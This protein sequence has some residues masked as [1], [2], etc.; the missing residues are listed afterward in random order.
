VT[1]YLGVS[2]GINTTW[3]FFFPLPLNCSIPLFLFPSLSQATVLSQA[4][5]LSFLKGCSKNVPDS[6]YS[7]AN[8][9]LKRIDYWDLITGYVD[10]MGEKS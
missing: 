7:L 3:V 10:L 2:F 1:Q 9:L 5:F 8:M 6:W 4:A